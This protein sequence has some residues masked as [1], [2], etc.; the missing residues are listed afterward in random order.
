MNVKQHMYEAGRIDLAV[1]RIGDRFTMRILPKRG[2]R[3]RIVANV[4][5]PGCWA[6][7]NVSMEN[8]WLLEDAIMSREPISLD[9]MIREL[10]L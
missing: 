6:E 9:E 5:V 8:V 4:R 3:Q 2:T 7:R 10:G 1:D